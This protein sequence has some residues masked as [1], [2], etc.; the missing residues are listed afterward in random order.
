[1]LFNTGEVLL[2]CSSLPYLSP[3][4]IP[5]SWA[6]T[7]AISTSEATGGQEF[8]FSCLTS[9]SAGTL[10]QCLPEKCVLTWVWQQIPFPHRLPFKLIT[11]S[12]SRG[13]ICQIW[14]VW[15]FFPGLQKFSVQRSAS[16]RPW[17]W[18]KGFRYAKNWEFGGTERQDWQRKDWLPLL[19]RGRLLALGIRRTLR[20]I[21]TFELTRTEK[22]QGG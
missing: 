20:S 9:S 13:I 8:A 12:T 4:S 21:S 17:H 14:F 22:L 18:E 3:F 10:G 5:P 6:I 16:T 11:L 2:L 7:P 19:G 15:G 1:M